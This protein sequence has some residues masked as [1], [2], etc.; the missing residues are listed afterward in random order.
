M[1]EYDA[2]VVG[3]GPGGYV[4]A[5]RTAQL[6][7]RVAVAEKEDALGGTCLRVGCIPS[8]A[9]LESSELFFKA[10]REFRNHGIRVEPELDLAAMMKRKE[11]I[12]RQLTGGVGALFKKNGI[13]LL[14][15]E[16]RL[17]GPSSLLVAGNEVR[18]KNIILATGSAPAAVP[19]IDFDGEMIV[20]SAGGLS[21]AEA[22]GELVVIGAGY[23]GLEMGSIWA[24]LGSKVTVLEYLPRIL[25][26][27]DEE[28]ARLARRLL[29]RQGLKIETGVKVTGAEVEAGRV[30]VH[31]E[32]ENEGDEPRRWTA[33]RLLVAVGRKPVTTGLGLDEVGV[34]LDNT[35]RVAVDGMYR[36]NVPGIYAIGDVIAG[37]ML[38]H[39][40]SE[41]GVAAAQIIAGLPGRVNYEALPGVVYIDPEIASVG[42]TEEQLREEGVPYRKGACPFMV[43]G[44]AKAL[45]ARDGFVKILAH[46]T[47]G[48]VLGA[49][50]IGPR[51]G[52]LIAELVAV[53]EFGGS[54]QDVARMV[55]AHP[56]LAEVS[57]EAALAV[58][59]S[60]I[61]I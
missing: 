52:D 14:R 5:I 10:R 51:A 50:V 23:I 37:P 61:H 45:G 27:T 53:M 31:A 34:E 32:G 25:P 47:T 43:N 56:T 11:G 21:F 19:G 46:E 9:L 41:E 6:G 24:R 60:A 13:E 35:G 8:K 42:R 16:A 29:G 59:G 33:D 54:A 1:S 58:D 36:S 20:D 18:A 30:T 48:R 38:A 49:H 44:R 55:R 39:K 15:G 3:A 28:L 2:I 57:K 12:V 40:A 4:A 17:T 22:P 26:G 7:L